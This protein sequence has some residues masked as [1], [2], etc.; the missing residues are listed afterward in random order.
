[1]LLTKKAAKEDRIVDC[2]LI[3]AVSAPEVVELN[4]SA[5]EN[6]GGVTCKLT[7]LRIY[8]GSGI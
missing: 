7:G 5:H 6:T 2:T 3:F 1:L 4:I 8:A